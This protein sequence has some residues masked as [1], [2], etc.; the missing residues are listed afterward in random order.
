M[1]RNYRNYREDEWLNTIQKYIKNAK[2]YPLVEVDGVWVTESELK[3]IKDINNKALEK[4]A[5]TLLCLAKFNNIKNIKNN[6]WVNN[7]ESVLFRLSRVSSDKRKKAKQISKLRELGLVEYAKKID[8][9]SL[10]VTFIDE[11]SEKELF[12][13]DFR[14][15]GYEYLIYRGE[16]LTRCADCNILVRNNKQKTRKYCNE[17][18]AKSKYYQPIGTKT[19]QCIDCGKEVEVDSK[20]NNIKRCDEC[21]KIAWNEYNK[22]KQREYYQRKKQNSV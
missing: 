20:A 6:N 14:E 7:E 18:A 19:I 1:D 5:F 8:N 3:I 16:N 15:L 4:L 21:S 12:I 10:K 13:S 11:D 9:L 2:K 17:C 22:A